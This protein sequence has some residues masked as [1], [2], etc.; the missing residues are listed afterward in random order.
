MDKVSTIINPERSFSDKTIDTIVQLNEFCYYFEK[1]K[2]DFY[3][4]GYSKNI[5][6]CKDIVTTLENDKKIKNKFKKI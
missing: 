6:S 4:D 1:N 2:N 5:K 3:R